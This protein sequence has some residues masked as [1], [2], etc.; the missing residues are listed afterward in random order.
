M[1]YGGPPFSLDKRIS[2]LDAVERLQQTRA[3]TRI[4]AISRAQRAD[5]LAHQL[6]DLREELAL[7][8]GPTTLDEIAREANG[9]GLR[10][11]RGNEWTASAV[12]RALTRIRKAGAD[13]PPE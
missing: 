13:G 11:S 6:A 10:T 4:S 12:A 1:G 5:D 9:R 8:Q 2:P 3:A 7:A